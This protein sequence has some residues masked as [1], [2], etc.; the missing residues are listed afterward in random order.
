MEN[1]GKKKVLW[2]VRGGGGRTEAIYSISR[3]IL[4]HITP[5]RRDWQP[6]RSRSSRDYIYIFVILFRFPLPLRSSD[7]EFDVGNNDGDEDVPAATAAFARDLASD[8]AHRCG[9]AETQRCCVYAHS[10]GRRRIAR[11]KNGM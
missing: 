8:I 2:D 3:Y 11:K 7:L 1:M 5:L 10:L 9:T 6:P 4:A